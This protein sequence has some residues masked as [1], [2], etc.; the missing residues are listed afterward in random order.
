MTISDTEPRAAAPRPERAPRAPAAPVVQARTASGRSTAPPRSTATRSGSRSTTAWPCASA[1][2]TSTPRAASRRSTRPTCTAASACGGCTPS[3]SPA[4]TAAAP[5]PSTP[6]ELEDEYFMLRVRIDGGQLTTE[7]LRVIA[8][9]STEFGRDTADLTDRQNIQLH[10]IRGRG[11]ARDLA[12]PRGRR[13]RHDRGVRRR[14]ARRPRLPRRRH[15]GRR[16]HRP[17]AA[18]RRDHLALH[19][20]RVAREPPPQVQVRDHRPPEPGRRARDQRR[21]VRRRRAPRARHR[22]RP[23]G[24]RRPVDGTPRSASASACSSRPSRWRMPGTASRRS[25]AT[26]AT[27]ACATRR[28]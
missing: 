3:A 19:R 15:R 18:D 13:A 11:R 23:V 25:S 7:Q 24:R 1:S 8:G 21:R 26:T 27:G 6:E 5:R 4:S 14:A 9:I 22:L 20:R 12:P 10:W 17:D 28:A 2:R 16:A